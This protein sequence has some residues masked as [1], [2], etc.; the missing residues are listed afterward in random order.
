MSSTKDQELTSVSRLIEI[1]EQIIK[2]K[3]EK[4]RLSGKIQLMEEQLIKL[5]GTSD[6][7]K[8][9]ELISKTERE[10]QEEFAK[11]HQAAS[12]LIKGYEAA[13]AST[14]GGKDE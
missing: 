11:I 7:E 2:D 13:T 10:T 6:I 14:K 5:C 12:K 4:A 3:E 8:I 9:N 1:K